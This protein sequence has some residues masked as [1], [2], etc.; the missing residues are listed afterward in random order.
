MLFPLF[1]RQFIRGFQDHIQAG[2]GGAADYE[3]EIGTPII[4]PFH[5]SIYHFQ[6]EKGGN[7]IGIKRDDGLR[8]EF[9]HLSKY[10]LDDKARCSPGETIA[11][12]GNSGSETTGPHLHH[13]IID[14]G[15]RIDPEDFYFAQSLPI[16]AVNGSIPQLKAMQDEVLKY[17]QGMLTI[18]WNIIDYPLYVGQGMLTQ[19]E[20]YDLSKRLYDQRYAPYRYIFMFYHGNPLAT[21]TASFWNPSQRNCITTIPLTFGARPLAFEMSHQIQYW[22]NENRGSNPFVQIIDS[23]FPS[24]DLIVSKYRSVLPYSDILLK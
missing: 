17:S 6:E 2:L 5:G 15:E 20:A 14:N 11:L 24:D 12:T 16:V 18:N 4:S 1:K 7:W 10:V 22:Y 9:A 23:N 3:A 8:F 13:Q 21:F 19:T